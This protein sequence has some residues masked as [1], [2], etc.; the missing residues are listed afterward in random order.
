MEQLLK[1][2]VSAC[3]LG[4]EVRFN[5]GHCN[6]RFLTHYFSKYAVF[7]PVCPEVAIGMGIPRKS[8][9]LERDDATSDT[10]RMI[11]P[12]SGH[13]YTDD[14]VAYSA[15]KAAELHDL[16]GFVFK[17]NSPSCGVFRVKIYQN[18]QPSERR[19]TGLFAQA[20]MERYPELPVEEEGRLSDPFLRENFVE[21][22]FAYRRVKDLFDRQWNRRDVIEFQSR[23]KLLLMAHAPHKAKLLGQL[24]GRIKQYQ[25]DDFA[26]AYI[27]AYMACMNTNPSKGRHTNAMMHMAGY[28][29]SKLSQSGRAELAS[30]ISDYRQGYVPMTV[31]MALMQH[32]IRR[33]EEGYLANQTY[34]APHPRDL[35]LRNHV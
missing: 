13:D 25:R 1:I 11:E 34:L 32:M 26:A 9:R 24:V 6:H 28:L 8:V 16:D 18:D 12:K 27:Q 10:V 14:M 21:R 2:G 19:G 4:Q 3:L 30:V 20:I 7:E 23:E 31:P 33:L 29:K 5:G 15:E 17:K 35:A 22:V